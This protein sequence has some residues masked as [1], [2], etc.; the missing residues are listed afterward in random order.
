[1]FRMGILGVG[2][3]AVNAMMPAFAH[4]TQTELCALATRSESKA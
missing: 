2:K 4:S 1:M 3:I